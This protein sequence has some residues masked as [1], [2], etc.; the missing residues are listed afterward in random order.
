MAAPEGNNNATKNRYWSD[1]LR[2]HITQNPQD[3]AD[4]AQAIF[5]KA[6]DGDVIA[7]KEIADRLEGKPAQSVN[8]GGQEDNPLRT[9]SKIELVALEDESTG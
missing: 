3:L 5:T 7:I 2:K 6:K 8:I 9:I 4:A 1:A